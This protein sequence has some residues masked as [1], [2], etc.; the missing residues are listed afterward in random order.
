MNKFKFS[1][2]VQNTFN[3]FNITNSTCENW[4]ELGNEIGRGKEAVVY[5]ICCANNCNYVVKHILPGSYQTEWENKIAKEIRINYA[6]PGALKP[7]DITGCYEHGLYIIYPKL[8]FNFFTYLLKMKEIGKSDDFIRQERDKVYK[9]LINNVNGFVEQAHKLG[10]VH[11]DLTRENIMFNTN[12]DNTVKLDSVVII[13]F[14]ISEDMNVSEDYKKF[15][16][17]KVY[18]TFYQI[19]DSDIDRSYTY[20]KSKLFEKRKEWEDLEK[21]KN[22]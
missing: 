1:K 17:K 3:K 18:E 4:S 7:I 12:P 15:D 22:C 8:Q 6:Y 21:K 5:N 16:L 20:L 10:I 2:C 13:D 19:I 14:G 11:R 9:V